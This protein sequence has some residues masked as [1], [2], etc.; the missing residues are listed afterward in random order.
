MEDFA[1]FEERTE[2]YHL[3]YQLSSALRS[4]SASASCFFSLTTV[5]CILTAAAGMWTSSD[6]QTTGRHRQTQRCTDKHVGELSS[7]KGRKITKLLNNIAPVAFTLFAFFHFWYL[8]FL[9]CFCFPVKHITP[10]CEIPH[11]R[12]LH[13]KPDMRLSPYDPTATADL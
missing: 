4:I 8:M 5:V 6:H 1:C 3:T 13:R 2:N 11:A 10:C 7:E 12:Q 9:F